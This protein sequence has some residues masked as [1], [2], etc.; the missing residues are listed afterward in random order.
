MLFAGVADPDELANLIAYLRT[1]S[2]LPKPLP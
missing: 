2:D 1:L